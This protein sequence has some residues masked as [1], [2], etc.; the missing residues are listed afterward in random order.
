MKGI[1]K[2][3]NR[4]LIALSLKPIKIV[5]LKTGVICKHYANGNIKTVSVGWQR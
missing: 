2:I 5:V 3:I 1:K 4:C